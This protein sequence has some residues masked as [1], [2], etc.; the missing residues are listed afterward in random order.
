M[1]ARKPRLV[2]PKRP[3]RPEDGDVRSHPADF[4][5]PH[6]QAVL[7]VAVRAVARELGRQYFR[8]LSNGTVRR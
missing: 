3:R 6:S 7:T 5:D 2:R 8:K 4:S 1:S